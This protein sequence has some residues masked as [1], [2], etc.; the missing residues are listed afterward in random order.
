M[1]MFIH[2]ALEIKIPTLIK[3]TKENILDYF[4]EFCS[5]TVTEYLSSRLL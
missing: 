3:V 1:Q 2:I 4:G 5:L